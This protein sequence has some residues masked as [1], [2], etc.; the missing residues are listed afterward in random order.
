MEYE[1]TLGREVLD[2]IEVYSQGEL[3]RIAEDEAMTCA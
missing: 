1:N 2:R 3:Q